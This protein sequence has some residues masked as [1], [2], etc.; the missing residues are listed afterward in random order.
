LHQLAGQAARKTH[1]FALDL[2][3]G[4][5]EQVQRFGVIAKVDAGFFE[6][7]VGVALDRL[8]ALFVKHLEVRNLAGD[9]RYR[10]RAAGAAGGA[11]GFAATAGAAATRC[12]GQGVG[13]GNLRRGVLHRSSP[14]PERLTK[15]HSTGRRGTCA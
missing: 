10:L 13:C 8:Q 5:S 9:K 14:T 1:P 7:G 15:T 2:A 12:I 3:T 11:L 4:S 6:D